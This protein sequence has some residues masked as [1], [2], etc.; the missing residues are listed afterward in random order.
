MIEKLHSAY[1][2]EVDKE[3]MK[4]MSGFRKEETRFIPREHLPLPYTIQDY[5][6]WLLPKYSTWVGQMNSR[7]GDR[8]ACCRKFLL[9]IIPFLVETLVQD[10]IYFIVEFPRHPI[11]EYLKNR[12]PGYEQWTQ[13]AR[14]SVDI[15]RRTRRENELHALNNNLQVVVGSQHEQV[16]S[17]QREVRANREK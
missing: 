12:I 16:E 13:E 14:M 9:S 17:L 11:A 1:Q 2:S 6:N 15:I 8:S 7:R 10:S 3:T 5:T 4:V